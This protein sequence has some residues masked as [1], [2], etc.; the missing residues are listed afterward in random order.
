LWHAVYK[1]AKRVV[2]ALAGL[3]VV[4]AALWAALLFYKSNRDDEVK[5]ALAFYDKYNSKEFIVFRNGVGDFDNKNHDKIM[6][7][8][9]ELIQSNNLEKYKDTLVELVKLSGN[10]NDIDMV[11]EFFDGLWECIST[12]LCDWNTA[13]GLFEPKARILYPE[14]SPY[15]LYNRVHNKDAAYGYGLESIT[16]LTKKKERIL[17]RI[18]EIF[19]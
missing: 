14:F 17:D 9:N 8:L 6:A 10:E 4:I 2:K 19:D 18:L 13:V 15:I 3:S 12:N 11:I 5:T 16:N 1:V 7:A